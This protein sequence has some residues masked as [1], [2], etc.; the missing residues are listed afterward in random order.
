MEK[1]KCFFLIF[2]TVRVPLKKKRKTLLLERMSWLWKEWFCLKA[3]SWLSPDLV[4]C[5]MFLASFIWNCFNQLRLLGPTSGFYSI[6]VSKWPCLLVVPEDRISSVINESCCFYNGIVSFL[7]TI[8]C[9]SFLNIW[10]EV[11]S[12]LSNNFQS[13]ISSGLIERLRFNLIISFYLMKS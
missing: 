2:Y 1:W 4:N 3:G 11:L 7:T 6:Y 10:K 8:M 12:W 13:H 5:K 9:F